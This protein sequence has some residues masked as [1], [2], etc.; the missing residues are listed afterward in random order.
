M[1]QWARDESPGTKILLIDREL[2]SPIRF[3]QED[4]DPELVQ[5]AKD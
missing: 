1:Q 4:P 3:E 5:L 2:M